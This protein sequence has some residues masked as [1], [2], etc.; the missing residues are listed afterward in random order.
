ME[1]D[2][3]NDIITYP[4]NNNIKA[5]GYLNDMNG[6]QYNKLVKLKDKIISEKILSDLS[7]YEDA[8]LLKFLRAR[9]FDLENTI[10]MF[11]ECVNFKIKEK[12]EEIEHMIFDELPMLKK[13]YPHA[14]HKTDKLVNFINF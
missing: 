12:V 2:T 4:I 8:T 5:S 11:A 6:H 13:L 7:D 10:Q 14:Y 9:K 3:D 1:H